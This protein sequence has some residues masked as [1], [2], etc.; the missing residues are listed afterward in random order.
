MTRY[1]SDTFDKKGDNHKQMAMAIP[2]TTPEI[3]PIRVSIRV[4]PRCSNKLL[5]DKFKNV[6]KI[7]EG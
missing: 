3:K 6:L 7:R 1:G 5:A 4:I 2:R